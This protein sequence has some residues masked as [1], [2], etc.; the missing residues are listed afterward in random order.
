MTVTTPA[1]SAQWYPPLP[2]GVELLPARLSKEFDEPVNVEV[3]CVHD[4]VDLCIEYIVRIKFESGFRCH[5][6]GK[7][8]PSYGISIDDRINELVRRINERR[9]RLNFD[10]SDLSRVNDALNAGILS[11]TEAL[12]TMGL[13]LPANISPRDYFGMSHYIVTGR[14]YGRSALIKAWEEAAKAIND[15]VID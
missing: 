13:K 7:N 15:K 9:P 5:F 10:L 1:A 3:E 6:Y 11:W 4:K 12:K 2:L 14:G 8:W